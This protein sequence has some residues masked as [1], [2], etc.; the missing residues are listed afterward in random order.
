MNNP[1][2]SFNMKKNNPQNLPQ[3]LPQN[4]PRNTIQGDSIDVLPTDR[5]L[6]SPEEAQ[7]VEN[8]FQVQ[9][10]AMER[11]AS[12]SKDVIIVGFLYVVFSLPQLDELIR[13]FIPQVEQS[14]YILT[15]IKALMFMIAFFILN[16][17]YLS[18]KD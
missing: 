5:N 10:S 11:I 16:N 15:A 7:I 6:I 9:Q 4:I 18:R 17:W 3:N 12:N 1:Q 14:P 2:I 8:V 13:K